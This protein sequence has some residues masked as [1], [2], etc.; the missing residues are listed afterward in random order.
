M[1]VE[2]IK[3]QTRVAYSCLVVGQSVVAGLASAVCDMDSAAAAAVCGFWCYL[4]VTCLMPMSIFYSETY[5][6]NARCSLFVLKMPLN[7]NQSI[8]R[9]LPAIESNGNS[10]CLSVA[11][12]GTLTRLVHHCVVSVPFRPSKRRFRDI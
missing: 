9:R 2:T 10:R 4:S 1:G 6:L 5:F 3:Q 12:V 7:T 8:N 11:G